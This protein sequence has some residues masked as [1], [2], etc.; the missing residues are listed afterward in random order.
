MAQL[1]QNSMFQRV[2][3]P[4]VQAAQN[5]GRPTSLKLQKLLHYR[6]DE[7]LS[8]A[9]VP[10]VVFDFETT[11]LDSENDRIVEVGAIKFVGMEPVAEFS[12]LVRPDV[13]MHHVAASV[14]GLTEE[15]LADAPLITDVLPEFLEFFRGAI[16]VAH[17]AEFDMSF[18][19][20][21][22]LREEIDIQWPCFCSLKMAR[23][24]LPE[25]ESKG[26]DSLAAHFGLQF[27]ARHRSIG[28]VKVTSKVLRELL[29]MK[30]EK[31]RSPEDGW[32]QWNWKD[33]QPYIV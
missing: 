12:S 16:L 11:G 2:F 33:L 10:I 29:G 6:P 23:A 21:A 27:E 24:L 5:T 28:D 32:R 20:A 4:P 13:T 14:T 19:K 31:V 3:F 26:L 15:M 30:I 7:F 9:D 17:N 25:L 8:L 1:L 18:L 22:C